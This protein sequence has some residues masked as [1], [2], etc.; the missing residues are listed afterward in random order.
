MKILEIAGRKV[1]LDS[2]DFKNLKAFDHRNGQYTNELPLRITD[3]GYVQWTIVRNGRT[4]VTRLH[5]LI[6]GKPIRGLEIDHINRDPL[7]N[8]RTNLR[9]VTPRENHHNRKHNN[10]LVGVC[11]CKVQSKFRASIRQG[12]RQYH[13]GYFDNPYIAHTKYE[14]CRYLI[15]SGQVE[16]FLK[17]RLTAIHK[18]ISL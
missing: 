6:M 4:L 17:H 12:V 18:E 14:W 1:I 15:E 7:D 9:I 11:W 16:R 10:N 3:R 2:A 8:R 13:L 5:H